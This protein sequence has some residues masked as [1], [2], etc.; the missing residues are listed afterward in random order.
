MRFH[1]TMI[2]FVFLFTAIALAE[3][4]PSIGIIDFY[5]LRQVS[6]EQAQQALQTKIG[7]DPKRVLREA[8]QVEMR[9]KALPGVLRARLN[10][11]CCD[12]GKAIL[13]VGIEERG[14]SA[15]QLRP[16]PQGRVRLPKD[17]VDAGH[18]L[19][20]AIENAVAKG[21]ASEDH[22]QG[23][24]LSHNLAAR[25]IQQRYI[26]FA[27]R[28]LNI[29]RD[30]LHNSADADQRAISAQVIA[31][32][33]DKRTIAPDLKY[34]VS[35][36]DD[37]VRNNAMRAL[38]LMAGFAQNHPDLKISVSPRPF[39]DMLNSLIW[40]D[41]NKSS[42]ALMNLTER[43]D[44]ALLADL[45]QHA[46]TSLV[47]MARWKITGH[48]MMSFVILGRIAGLPDKEIFDDWERGD[49][50]KV[51]VAAMNTAAA[52]RGR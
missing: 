46:L 14:A 42:M 22:S 48:A 24:A 7:D 39:V 19:D 30:V 50:E 52:I 31:Y 38:A 36:V 47:E 34:A 13:Y 5:G 15:L 35:D 33:A 40:S 18:A 10:L 21:D 29:L 11:V 1:N 23:Y 51:I 49:R 32:T 3:Q 8:R 45:R 12:A 26:T 2:L 16:A 41:R 20:R 4:M 9:L 27:A 37:G 28:D 17:I 44:P 25:A 6:K 43:R